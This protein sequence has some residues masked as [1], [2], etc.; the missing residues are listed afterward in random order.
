[1][2]GHDIPLE[3]SMSH[4]FLDGQGKG[5]FP[6]PCLLKELHGLHRTLRRILSGSLKNPVRNYKVLSF[7]SVF[8]S[9]DPF[10]QRVLPMFLER[11]HKE[12]WSDERWEGPIHG[13]DMF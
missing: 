9:S 7:M 3:M 12:T 5:E 4:G 13:T 1:M 8:S 6:S 11:T 2:T 10:L